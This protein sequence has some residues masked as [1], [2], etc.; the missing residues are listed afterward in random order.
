M[1][2][3][4]LT[5]IYIYIYIF[6]YICTYIY[7][8][9]IYTY[10]YIYANIYMYSLLDNYPWSCGNL[11]CLYL[12]IIIYIELLLPLRDCLVL[13]KLSIYRAFLSVFLTCIG[14]LY[15]KPLYWFV[16]SP[17]TDSKNSEFRQFSRIDFFLLTRDIHFPEYL[18]E[19]QVY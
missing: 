4:L 5:Y 6:I 14:S 7:I 18:P 9:Y 8:L 11:I 19:R 13:L 2:W 3:S 10:M 15:S 17:N 16:L 12:N 1:S